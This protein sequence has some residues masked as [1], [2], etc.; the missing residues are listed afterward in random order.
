M[1]N[2]VVSSKSGSDSVR[3]GHK[4][5]QGFLDHPGPLSLMP[6]TTLGS[7]TCGSPFFTESLSASMMPL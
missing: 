2:F 1:D 6:R 4:R 3:K 5:G 7:R